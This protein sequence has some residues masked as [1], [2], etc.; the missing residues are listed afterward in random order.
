MPEVN[1]LWYKDAVVYQIHVRAFHDSAN[2]GVGDFRGLTQKLDYLQDLGATALWLLPFYPSPLRDDGYDI[3]DYMSVHP[4]YGTL[5]D[6]KAFLREAHE[7]GLKVITELVLN[8]TSDQHPWFQRARRAKPGS[9]HRDYYVWSDTPTKYRDARIIFKDFETSNWTWDPVAHAYYWHRFYSHQPDLNFDHPDVRKAMFHVLDHWLGMGVD[10]LRLDAV[11]YLFEREG[12]N[13]ENLPETH[14]FLREIRQYVDA[15]YPGTML[16]AEAN[17]WPED[18]VAYFGGGSECHAAFHFPV[19]PRMFMAVQME[20]RFPVIDIMQ[21]TPEIPDTCQWMIFLRNHDELTLEMVTDEER[22]YMY[23]MYAHDPQSRIN[24]GIRRRL[25]PLLGNHRRKIELLNSLLLSLPGTPVI[26]YGDEIGMGDN[27]Y[28]GDRNGVRTPMQWSP[29]RNAGFSLAN[30]QQ[31]YLPLIIDH[32]YHYEAVNVETSRRNPYSLFWW[33]KRIIALRQQSPIFSRGSLRFLHSSNAKVLAFLRTYQEQSIL[34]V[35]NLSRF[36]QFVELDLG[37]FRGTAPVELFGQ[38]PF[39]QIG[40]LPYLLTLGPHSFYW[41][42]VQQPGAKAIGAAPAKGAAATAP[43]RVARD[44]QRVFEDQPKRALE[45][46][47]ARVI[48]TRRW[49]S[50]KAK[51]I[52]TATITDVVDLPSAQD[53]QQISLLLVRMEYVADEPEVYLLPLAFATGDAARQ[54]I[55]D[56]SPALVANLQVTHEETM[57]EGVLYDAFGGEQM[58]QAL[59][60]LVAARRRVA[61]ASGRLVGH[62]ARA[63]RAVRGP[64]KERLPVR[65]LKVEQSNSS[66]VYGERLYMKMFRRLEEGVNPEVEMGEFLTDVA[67][68]PHIPPLA[69]SIEYCDAQG[70]SSTLAVF[71]GFVH[72]EC[73]AW[74]YTLDAVRRFF[75]RVSTGAKNLAPSESLLPRKGLVS[76]TQEGIAP[77]VWV[78][79]NSYLESASLLGRRT[80]E[81]HLALASAPDNPEF[82]PEPFSELYQRSLYQEMRG[83]TRKTFRMLRSRFSSVAEEDQPEVRTLLMLEQELLDRLRSTMARK[84]GGARLRCHGD[85]HLGQVFY[86]GKDFVIID[87]EGEPMRHLSQ[88]RIKRSPLRDVAGMIR[89]FDYASQSAL[90][91]YFSGMLQKEEAAVFRKWAEFWAVWNSVAFLEEY[92]DTL[93]GSALLPQSAEEVQMLLEAYLLEK[94]VYEVGYEL[95]N[96]PTWL[97]VPIQ[98]ILRILGPR[99][100][101]T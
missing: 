84:L 54:M 95:N 43:L 14:A 46:C 56:G 41:F 90:L 23:R 74:T 16:L 60:D 38:T 83:L 96:R 72:G 32:E 85:Y 77:E 53:G 88:R 29:D 71:Q 59:L 52:R 94:A 86:T 2:D 44:W 64:T 34:V 76:L 4:S 24:L 35:A 93:R 81:L 37:E 51:T 21:Q 36:S 75:D 1:P 9:R 48:P 82:A 97:G 5:Q 78:K 62:P 57:E 70:K 25:A 69:G 67:A 101:A 6:F 7:R 39:P 17:Q 87:F 89:S 3:A 10:G 8:H 92:L 91:N 31:L 22:D 40:E 49:F 11:P 18:A 28:L 99:E 50:G 98:G 42:S 27:I 61:G 20:D 63:F 100:A 79:C 45:K 65:A 58:S 55:A 66:V 80:A 12:T 68:L 47:L 15:H 26:Y 13:C 33:M 73:D 19:M 30:P